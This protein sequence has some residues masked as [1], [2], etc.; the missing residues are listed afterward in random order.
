M[1][2]KTSIW[3]DG[4]NRKGG[5]WSALLI[6]PLCFVVL[7]EV[8]LRYVFDSPTIWGFEATTF[9]YGA[10]FMLGLAYTSVTDGHVKVDIFTARMKPKAQAIFN[11]VTNG[12]IF[13]P[14]FSCMTV[15]AW[16]YAIT[17][18]AQREL[19]STSWAPAIWPVKLIMALC[20]S[21][22]LIQGMSTLIKAVRSLHPEKASEPARR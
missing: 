19:N 13:L 17:S 9:L 2:E 11:I 20:F 10:H 21:L 1:L 14:V 18:T 5:E 12:V 15:W 22:L 4:V 6:L 16:K 3:I 8:I 7:Y